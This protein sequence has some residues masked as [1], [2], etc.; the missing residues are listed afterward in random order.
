M[1]TSFLKNFVWPL[2][3]VFILIGCD[4]VDPSNPSTEDLKRNSFSIEVSENGNTTTHEG[5]ATAGVDDWVGS[6]VDSALVG[7]KALQID[8]QLNADPQGYFS[9][10]REAATLEELMSTGTF[11]LGV[12][13]N[14][15]NSPDGFRGSYNEEVCT[16]G[17]ITFDVFTDQQID[18]SFT[19][20]TTSSSLN[21]RFVVGVAYAKDD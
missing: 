9:I 8:L 18:G 3:A 19:C 2:T 21:G 5:S 7:G 10:R 13:E 20:E 11:D 6:A 16:T 17:S 14:E 12:P 15:Q 4:S 1:K